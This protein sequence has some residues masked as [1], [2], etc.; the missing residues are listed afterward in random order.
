MIISAVCCV[1]F[2]AFAATINSKEINLYYLTESYAEKISIP[3]NY[4]KSFQLKVSGASSVSY[5][6]VSGDTATVSSSGLVQPKGTT[7]YWYGSMGTTFPMPDYGEPTRVETDYEEGD[8]VIQVRADKQTFNVNVHVYDYSVVYAD[9]V[10]NNYIKSNVKSGMTD[11]EKVVLCAKFTASYDYSASYSSATS[12]IIFG[13][14]DCWAST[15]SVI[16]M[17]EKFGFDAWQR[18]GN[19]DPGAGTGHMNAMVQVTDGTYYEVEAGYSNPSPR[20]YNVK[21]RTSLFSTFYNPYSDN[22]V[23]VYQYDGKTTPASLVVP[24]TFD[25]AP[26]TEIGEK[27]IQLN[28]SVKQVQL[29]DTVKIIGDSAFNSCENL[30]SINIPASLET[31]GN[32]VFTKCNKLTDIK[33]K[34][35]NYP[36]SNG[37]IYNKD[38]SVLLYAPAVNSINIPASVKTIRQYAFYHNYN[39]KNAVVPNTVKVIEEGAFGNCENL[40]SVTL[41]NES[42]TDIGCFAFAYCYKLERIVVPKSVSLIDKNAFYNCSKLKQVTVIN[43]NCTIGDSEYTFPEDTVL[44]G[45]SNSTLE[46]YANKYKRKFVSIDNCR[47]TSTAEVITKAP[48]CTETGT[49]DIR[50]NICDSVVK[51][52]VSIP[53]TQHTEVVDIQAVDATCTE[54]GRTKGSHCSVCNKI[55]SVSA[56]IP[57]AGHKYSWKTINSYQVNC[58]S[59][60]GFENYRLK[61]TDLKGYEIYDDYVVY[62]SMYN[63]FIAGTNPPKY[64]LFSPRTA[65]TRAMFVAILYRMAGNPYDG[66]NPYDSNPFSDIKEN[67]YYYNAACWALDEGITNQKTFKPNNN[68]TREQTA[69]FLFAYAESKGLL[70][71]EAYKNVNLSRYP[72][73]NS[74]HSWAVEPLQW[75]NYNNMITGT[76]QGYINPQGAT[77]RIH[78]TRILYGFGKV[79]N[80]GN[81]E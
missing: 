8:T 41:F 58:C 72:D 14:G 79:C 51:S 49:K 69:R 43:K 12:M 29:P 18:N 38:K 66:A 57:A 28:D 26:V 47:H 46:A 67:A 2:S 71:D 11:Y 75:A 45:Y 52:N 73:Y 25:G 68:V 10:M 9:N 53:V 33:S 23:Y 16:K 13:G 17:A 40:E 77:Q 27:F 21:E 59:K 76:S 74:V 7:W 54:A 63:N 3:N 35:S 20:P 31:L 48:T 1:D 6:V 56:E 30:E 64:T 36:A 78:A 81:F 34:S 24:N 4:N 55:L 50:C 80:I 32:F 5:S 15:D 44:Y 61:F 65:I 39:I 42:L 37:M 22:G 70:G 19:R 62:T 60:C